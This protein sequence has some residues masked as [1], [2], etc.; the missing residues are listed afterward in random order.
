MI[1]R[2]F[3]NFG[4]SANIRCEICAKWRIWQFFP[5]VFAMGRCAVG[6]GA[7]TPPH[8]GNGF[9][10]QCEHWLGMTRAGWRDAVPYTRFNIPSRRAGPACPAAGY[11][12]FGG[13][14]GPRPTGRY[15]EPCVGDGVPDVPPMSFRASAHTGVG[16]RFSSPPSAREVSAR[17]A[18]GGREATRFSLPQSAAPTAPSQRGPNSAARSAVAPHPHIPRQNHNNSQPNFV[19]LSKM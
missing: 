18:D 17:S 15:V 14:H 9:P 3:L 12:F 1:S 4:T 13:A 11:A 8:K 16:I 6:R 10:R 19:H 2:N 7:L 5:P